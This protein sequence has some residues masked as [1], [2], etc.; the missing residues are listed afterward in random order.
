MTESVPSK[1]RIVIYFLI[2][3]SC[4]GLLIFVP[5]FLSKRKSSC[6]I[7]VASKDCIHL[8][9]AA[10]DASR[11][12]GLSGKD[13][14]SDTEGMLF[15][16]DGAGKQCMWMKDMKFSL[17]M[18]WVD[19][20]KTITHLEKNVSPNSYPESFCGGDRDKYVV[21]LNTGIVERAN[22]FVGKK[23]NID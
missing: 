14:M 1:I 19:Q 23:L 20:N 8:Q 7:S 16:F 9:L 18:V 2:A 21:E 17:D 10:T 15:V 5:S 4:F 12:N 22:L 3:V 11:Q 6:A 13:S